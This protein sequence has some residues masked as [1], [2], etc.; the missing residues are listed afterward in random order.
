M[1]GV[2]VPLAEPWHGVWEFATHTEVTKSPRMTLR[3]PHW[4]FQAWSYEAHL[5]ADRRFTARLRQR[6]VNRGALVIYISQPQ[7]DGQ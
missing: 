6:R 1:H 4:R 7:L 3:Q 2:L 5:V